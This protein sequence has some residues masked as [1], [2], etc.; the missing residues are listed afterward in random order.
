MFDSLFSDPYAIFLSF[1]FSMVGWAA[2]RYGKATS[3]DRHMYLAVALMGF[4]YFISHFWAVL[5]IGS[6]L[7][8]LLFWP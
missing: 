7:T 2:W 6:V 5:G 4:G 8:L 1:F 3:S